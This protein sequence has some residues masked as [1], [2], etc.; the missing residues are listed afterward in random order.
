MKRMPSSRVGRLSLIPETEQEAATLQEVCI[1][2]STKHTP[3]TVDS[4]LLNK[5]ALEEQLGVRIIDGIKPA[6][7]VAANGEP[8]V[9]LLP[10]Q[11]E[12]LAKLERLPYVLNANP[13]GYGKTVEA[14]QWAKRRGYK[15]ILIVCPKSIRLQWQSAVWEWFDPEADV[16]ISPATLAAP[17]V[18]TNYEQL[19]RKKVYL[20]RVWD[21]IIA[22]EVHRAR[23][24]QTQTSIA[25][26]ALQARG[27]IG[28]T[29]TPIMNQPDD[30]WGI[31]MFVNPGYLGSSYWNFVGKYCRVDEDFWGK[32]IVGGTENPVLKK[33][34]QDTLEMFWVRNPQ[35]MVGQ[36]VRQNAVTLEMYPAQAALYKS[37]K[38]LAEKELEEAQITIA[39]AMVQL[40]ALQRL[41]TAPE[42][43]DTYTGKNIKGEWIQDMLEDNPDLKVCIFS[44]FK[45][46]ILAL[47]RELNPA[48]CVTIH[49][50]VTAKDRE[51]ARRQFIEDSRVRV[52]AGT[53]GAM[54]EGIDGLQQVCHTVVFLDCAWNPEENNQAIARVARMGQ[55]YI[56]NAYMLYC[57]GTIDQYVGKVALTKMQNIRDLIYKEG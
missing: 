49:G 20:T 55:K 26:R 37:I 7:T 53:I 24:C 39:N 8:D 51:S 9:R 38:K 6:V 36:G 13:M 42:T 29:G 28:L 57:A 33:I 14:L 21:C 25:L 45:R 40:M 47:Q 11:K 3:W 50:D 2:V 15:T 10:Y 34:L 32:K 17:V 35:N 27:R 48:I 31:C 22:D 1:G 52:I 18:I 30:L 23:N 41:T 16:D 46:A 19:I 4:C 44:K 12:D 54:S 56:V 5:V 43:F